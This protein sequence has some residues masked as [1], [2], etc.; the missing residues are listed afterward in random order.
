MEAQKIAK[1]Q[2]RNQ[3]LNWLAGDK[4]Q[5]SH[6]QQSYEAYVVSIADSPSRAK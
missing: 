2:K 5:E 6:N 4:L 1:D 3:L